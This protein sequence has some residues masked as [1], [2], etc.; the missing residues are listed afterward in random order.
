MSRLIPTLLGLAAITSLGFVFAPTTARAAD[1][2]CLADSGSGGVDCS[3]DTLAECQADLSGMAGE[4][5]TEPTTKVVHVKMKMPE[6]G[7]P[8]NHT[9]KVK[10]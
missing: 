8:F 2:V 9:F 7:L 4:C 1:P 3:F 10:K 5:V 6:K